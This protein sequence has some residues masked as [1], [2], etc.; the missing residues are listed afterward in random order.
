[1]IV[2]WLIGFLICLLDIWILKNSRTVS[3]WTKEDA[4]PVLKMWMVLVLIISNV[5]PVVNCIVSG[6][7]LI[8]T[9]IAYLV[10]DMQWCDSKPSRIISFL[11]K[12][13]K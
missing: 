7:I 1:M 4:R 5:V 9:G 12:D 8:A 11:N 13:I 3:L 2:A 6:A 10:D